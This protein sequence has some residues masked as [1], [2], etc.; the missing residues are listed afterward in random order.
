MESKRK[1]Q[2]INS[3]KKNAKKSE[4][5]LDHI[6]VYN[7]KNRWEKDSDGIITIF[8]ENKGLFH[9]LAQKLLK[10]PRFSQIHLDEMGSFILPLIDG[11]RSVYDIAQLVKEHFGEQ[12]EPLYNRLVTYMA[13]L[14]NCQFVTFEKPK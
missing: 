14:E 7:E 6:P 8:V 1:W 12:A 10:K 4:N 9:S 5:Y 11:Q 3:M 2:E 13:M